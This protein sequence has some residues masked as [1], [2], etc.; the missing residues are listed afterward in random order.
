MHLEC[1]GG[2]E[3]QPIECGF[4]GDVESGQGK[5]TV[6]EVGRGAIAAEERLLRA[7]R[8]GSD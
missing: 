1:S 3:E 7:S 8:R 6:R 4:D 2:V 5:D